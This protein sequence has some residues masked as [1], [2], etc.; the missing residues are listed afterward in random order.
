MTQDHAIARA[1]GTSA[2]SAIT[3][4]ARR[5][6]HVEGGGAR[7][8]ASPTGPRLVGYCTLQAATDAPMKKVQIF[9]LRTAAP[10]LGILFPAPGSELRG[11][12]EPPPRE[13]GWPAVFRWSKP[14]STR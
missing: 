8:M 14:A 2:L 11:A 7:F 12:L 3:R 1:Q 5:G 6:Y 13:P 10:E 9:T 4:A